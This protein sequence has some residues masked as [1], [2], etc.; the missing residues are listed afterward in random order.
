LTNEREQ[1]L[2]LKCQGY[3]TLN[4]SD[5]DASAE[6]RLTDRMTQAGVTP[7]KANVVAPAA[8]YLTAILEYVS[9]SPCCIPDLTNDYLTNFRSMCE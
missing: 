7:P 4:E 6:A 1:L 8:L 5:E 3:S 2:R 9:F